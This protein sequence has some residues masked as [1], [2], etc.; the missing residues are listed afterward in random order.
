MADEALVLWKTDGRVGHI[1][2]NRPQA[3][4]AVDLTL[5]KALAAAVDEAS[6]A[7][8]AGQVGALLLTAHGK[9]FCVGGD[10][11]SFIARRDDLPALVDE[12]LCW[13]HPAVHRLATSPVPVISVVQGALGGAGIALALCADFVLASDAIKLRGGYS[14]IGL[15][16]DVGASYFVAQRAGAAVARRIFMRNQ[17]ISAQECLQLGLVDELHTPQE[18]LPAAVRLAQ[19]LAAG[20]TGS[21]AAVKQLCNSAMRNDLHAHLQ[22]EHNTLLARAGSADSREGIQAFMAKRAPNFSRESTN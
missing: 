21:L 5:A 2:L 18:L 6:Q 3:G 11:Q 7:V 1:A 20:A 12:I 8:A 4:N 10:I 15:S 16:P 19:Q 17:S 22:L 9:Q 14:A 13:I